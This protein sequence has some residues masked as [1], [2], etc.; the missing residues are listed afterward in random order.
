MTA[1]HELLNVPRVMSAHDLVDPKCDALSVMTYVSGFRKA[2]QEHV[3]RM[4]IQQA[5]AAELALAALRDSHGS[6]VTLLMSAIPVLEGGN[7]KLADF[8]VEDGDEDLLSDDEKELLA[9]L[10]NVITHAQPAF[11][12]L[13]GS[14]DMMERLILSLENCLQDAAIN[15]DT[16]AKANATAQQWA[17]A[18]VEECEELA[19]YCMQIATIAQ[20]P[21]AWRSPRDLDNEAE[22][23]E[24]YLVNA[25]KTEG[26]TVEGE[27]EER[28][29]SPTQPSPVRDS[30]ASATDAVDGV[31]VVA[32]S[33]PMKKCD[34]VDPR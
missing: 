8:M 24:Q 13:K 30:I 33:S 21:F 1:A 22:T 31:D 14:G 25:S 17:G 15:P 19:D 28:F 4:R 27:G 20:I 5:E 2:A 32:T 11:H 12:K 18:V 26:A 23:S 10:A 7:T 16:L 3:Q 9:D 6:V 29:F 34:S